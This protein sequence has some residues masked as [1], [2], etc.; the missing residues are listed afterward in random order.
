MIAMTLIMLYA[1]LDHCYN[2]VWRLSWDRAG[3][4]ADARLDMDKASERNAARPESLVLRNHHELVVYR[5]E[6]IVD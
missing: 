5:Y 1:S 6:H 2:E 4:Q 3:A